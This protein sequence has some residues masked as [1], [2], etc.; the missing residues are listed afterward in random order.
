MKNSNVKL[1]EIKPLTSLRFFFAIMVFVSHLSYLE[2]SSNPILS[3][4]FIN[5]FSEGYIGVSFFFIL[6]GFILS[7]NYYEK[8][9][10]GQYPF[11]LFYINRF[12]R[13]YPL[14]ILTFLISFIFVSEYFIE[15]PI[16]YFKTSLIHIFLL[17]SF[18]KIPKIHINFNPPSWSISNEI[19]FYFLTP[20]LF[21]AFFKL[22]KY[23][24]KIIVV[25]LII[26]FL[27]IGMSVL[28]SKFARFIFYVNPLIRV[29]D[30]IMGIFL[31]LIYKKIN[32][33]NFSKLY[34]TILELLSIIIF[35][36]F[37][38][39]HKDVSQVYRYSIYYWLPILFIIFI[40]SNQNGWISK[41]LS[42]KVF[43]YLGEISFGFYMIHFLA[44]RLYFTYFYVDPQINSGYFEIFQILFFS[45]ICSILSFEFYEKRANIY[46]KKVLN[47]IFLKQV[48]LKTDKNLSIS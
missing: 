32:F 26:I 43:I 6:S 2:K 3:N 27:I 16:F 12:S 22:K 14:H 37:L 24:I 21:F 42:Q 25:I 36:I 44:I 41:L 1:T 4:L 11:K 28:P 33:Q 15:N 45:I 20:I 40:F 35:S 18:F 10:T 17:Q 47:K 9:T 7:Y 48:K 13:I 8:I 30:F 46:L 34:S 19:F 5:F 38:T 23:V 31:Y 39:F 29:F